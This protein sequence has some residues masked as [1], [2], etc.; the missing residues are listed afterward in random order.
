[1]MR[2]LARGPGMTLSACHGASMTGLA[3]L[4]F[5][6]T[7][8]ACHAAAGVSTGNRVRRQAGADLQVVM[9]TIRPHS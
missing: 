7:L 9:Y 5:G 4:A 1:M 2:F 6:K 3:D 8:I